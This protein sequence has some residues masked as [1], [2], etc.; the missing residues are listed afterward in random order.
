MALGIKAS[1]LLVGIEQA[2][3][4]SSGVDR[5]ISDA[6]EIVVDGNAHPVC[7]AVAVEVQIGLDDLF[8]GAGWNA[9]K[10]GETAARV[11]SDELLNLNS[12]SS[13]GSADGM[14]VST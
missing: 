2:G 11:S 4:G 12:R 9:F 13:G 3:L 5:L 7:L 14:D 6:V 8:V 1:Q 10:F